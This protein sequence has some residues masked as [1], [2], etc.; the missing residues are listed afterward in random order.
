MSVP[1]SGWRSFAS[2]REDFEGTLNVC[3]LRYFLPCSCSLFELRHITSHYAFLNEVW[4]VSVSRGLVYKIANT[5]ECVRIP[6]GIKIWQGAAGPHI[7]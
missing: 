4:H 5:T 6:R 3:R 7:N 1:L 2:D